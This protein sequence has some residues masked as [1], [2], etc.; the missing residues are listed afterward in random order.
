MMA[1]VSG[2]EFKILLLPLRRYSMVCKLATRHAGLDHMHGV[3]R[4]VTKLLCVDMQAEF[5]AQDSS[6]DFVYSMMRLPLMCTW[7]RLL[8]TVV[9]KYVETVKR[10]D[11]QLLGFRVLRKWA[12]IGTRAK[13]P[14][15][16]GCY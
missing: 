15:N 12:V 9:Q 4:V 8:Y 16:L 6:H 1:P 2:W 14:S 10:Q 7:C 3:G 13:R 5:L 11:L